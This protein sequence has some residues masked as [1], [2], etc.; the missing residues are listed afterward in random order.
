MRVLAALALFLASFNALGAHVV[1]RQAHIDLVTNK[2]IVIVGDIDDAMVAS[3]AVQATL[4][5]ELP[6]PTLVIIS[7]GGGSVDS[8]KRIIEILGKLGSNI[9]VA[10]QFA[11]SMAFNIMTSCTV[12][13]ATP[14]THMVAHK[15][16]V[17]PDLEQTRLTAKAMRE[18]ADQLDK[19][20]AYWDERNSKA[21]HLEIPA[22]NKF[23][24][25]DHAWTV[26][27]LMVRGYLQGVG[28]VD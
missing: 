28:S 7:S 19:T 4:I 21:L 15:I 9:C 1:S 3:V 24:E 25:R 17:M 23:A 10:N 5:H 6:G 16:S 2:T 13:L 18:E 12:R 20:D 26:P 22:Y 27:E 14:G 11:H 8:G